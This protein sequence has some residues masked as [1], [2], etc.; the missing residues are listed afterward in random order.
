MSSSAAKPH[1]SE[2]MENALTKDALI[3]LSKNSTKDNPDKAHGSS[4]CR[5][6][7]RIFCHVLLGIVVLLV[8]IVALYCIRLYLGYR[9]EMAKKVAAAKVCPFA[10]LEIED[11]ASFET[12]LCENSDFLKAHD[13][14]GVTLLNRV[15][16]TCS[17]ELVKKLLDFGADPL[18]RNISSFRTPRFNALQT[19]VRMERDCSGVITVLLKQTLVDPLEIQNLKGDLLMIAAETGSLEN[20]LALFDSGK[21]DLNKIFTTSE[22]RCY[23]SYL[24]AAVCNDILSTVR[25]LLERGV[26]ANVLMRGEGGLASSGDPLIFEVLNLKYPRALAVMLV[27]MGGA[28]IFLKSRLDGRD[29]IQKCFDGDKMD[30][31]LKVFEFLNKRDGVLLSSGLSRSLCHLVTQPSACIKNLANFAKFA[32]TP[33]DLIC[34]NGKGRSLLQVLEHSKTSYHSQET[35]EYLKKVIKDLKIPM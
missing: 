4:C 31:L 10:A 6:C 29:F 15:V 32:K 12:L 23:F 20:F 16:Q 19:A 33:A 3:A 2:D 9:A 18:Q 35:F 14:N 1:S 34:D 7:C 30:V 25:F 21:F 27:E 5:S 28:D 11:Y 24:D 8:S 13:Q 22:S 17:G 26:S